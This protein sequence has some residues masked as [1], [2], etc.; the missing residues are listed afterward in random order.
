MTDGH[1]TTTD[2]AELLYEKAK[3][4]GRRRLFMSPA[5]QVATG[6]IAGVTIIFGIVA[7]GIV[8]ALVEPEPGSGVAQ[9]A[10]ALAF[11]IGLVRPFGLRPAS[12]SKSGRGMGTTQGNSGGFR[13]GTGGSPRS[14]GVPT[15]GR[16]ISVARGSQTPHQAGR[17][18]LVFQLGAGRKRHPRARREAA[19]TGDR[20][21]RRR[22]ILGRQ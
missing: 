6:M 22:H 8:T 9:V 13:P 14:P 21:P 3:L 7:L 10:G 1:S 12:T 18:S 17:P 20:R 2:R 15:P 11:G 16:A 19:R 5:E 4:E